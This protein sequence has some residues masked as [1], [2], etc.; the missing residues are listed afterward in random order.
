[1]IAS[2]NIG[3]MTQLRAHTGTPVL[4]VM[5]VLDRAYRSALSAVAA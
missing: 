3:C 2:A 5:E 1:V 4:H